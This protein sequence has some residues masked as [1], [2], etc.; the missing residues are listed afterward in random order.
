MR[1]VDNAASAQQSR[2]Q[3]FSND[4]ALLLRF[5]MMI[6]YYLTAGRR[7]RRSY[8]ACEARGEVFWVDEDPAESE[9]RL[10]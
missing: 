5:A 4:L 7:L 1:T 3:K 8:R 6:F 10:R 9:R 2:W